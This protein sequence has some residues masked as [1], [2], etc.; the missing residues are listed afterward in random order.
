MNP[1]VTLPWLA[2]S[3]IAVVIAIQVTIVGRYV[4]LLKAARPGRRPPGRP[5]PKAAI[6]LSVRGADPRLDA[7][8]AGLACQ[9]YPE[10]LVSIVVDS[11]HDPAWPIIR[12]MADRAKPG[13]FVVAVLRSRLET[14]SLKCA[15]LA[16]ALENLPADV[17]A[18]ALI[19]GDT[20]PHPSWLAD[21]VAAL[22]EPGVGAATG[23]RWYV[24]REP[25]FGGIV[26]HYWNAGAV[27]QVWLNGI[28]WAGSLAI[29][30]ETL[31][32]TGI[33]RS[34]RHSLADDGAIGRRLGMHRLAVRFVP[35]AMMANDEHI[36]RGAFADWLVRQLLAARSTRSGWAVVVAHAVTMMLC[37]TLPV[38]AFIGAAA[39]RDAVGV[40]LSA[41]AAAAYWGWCVVAS[42]MIDRA[43]RAIVIRQGADRQLGGAPALRHRLAAV[44][45]AHLIH[46]AA[47]I[48]ASLCTRVR[49]RGIEYEIVDSERV[50]MISYAAFTQDLVDT[51]ASLT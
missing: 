49:W 2:V 8:L 29:R 32:A 1:M 39:G 16:Q 47:L 50:R 36:S 14:C 30:R 3:L 40:V 26:R 6:V 43:V 31:V 11:R 4:A 5:L 19:D 10:Y 42:S 46:V 18:V 37:L 23:N 51:G 28:P 35:E 20:V 25:A 27:V 7:V 38:V 24:P 45:D 48:R 41:T 13:M 33:I 22:D 44:I 9:D 15:A 21:L 12:A 34:L 17:T